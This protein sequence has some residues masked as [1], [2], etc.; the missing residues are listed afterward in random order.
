[1]NEPYERRP[2]FETRH[3]TLRLVSEADAEDL[4]ACYSDPGAQKFFNTDNFSH[5]CNFHT[6]EEMA[7]CIRFWLAA[8]AQEAFVRF[9]VV[10]KASRK[11]VGTIEMFG[12]GMGVLRIDIASDYENK[13]HLKE[14]LDICLANFYGLFEVHTIAAKAAPFAVD[15]I[16]ALRE[17]GFHAG[18]FHGREHYYLRTK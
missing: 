11:A 9:S 13:A 16:D 18:D 14:L 4:L 7:S 15:R 8:Y 10:D 5:T 3:F 17:A 12:A 2:V 6:V 1:M